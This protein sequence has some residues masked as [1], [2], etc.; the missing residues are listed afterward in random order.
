MNGSVK[1][2]MPTGSRDHR[3]VVGAILDIWEVRGISPLRG[4][5]GRFFSQYAIR[6]YATREDN[7]S[8]TGLATG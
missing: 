5:L 2:G 3:G 7:L 4:P 6:R 8:E 1:E